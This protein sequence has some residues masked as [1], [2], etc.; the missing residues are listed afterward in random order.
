[1]YKCFFDVVIAV[2]VVVATALYFDL[3]GHSVITYGSK[4][5]KIYK[6]VYTV[7]LPVIMKMFP[8][9]Y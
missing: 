2:V 4:N 5:P 7:K 8:F 9:C 3:K 1:M 6:F